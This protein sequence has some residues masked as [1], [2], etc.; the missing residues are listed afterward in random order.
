MDKTNDNQGNP[1]HHNYLIFQT[2]EKQVSS[3]KRI[4][5][6]I[7]SKEYIASMEADLIS[8]MR[9]NLKGEDVS[10]NIVDFNELC[11][12]IISLACKKKSSFGDV[13]FIST[14]PLIAY[15]TGGTCLEIN[16]LI[17]FNGEIIGIGTRPGF[18]DLEQQISKVQKKSVV[19]LEDGSWTG[20]TMQFV[21]NGL[22]EQNI[23]VRA[24]ILGVLSSKAKYVLGEKEDIEIFP[25]IP[26]ASKYIEWMP[27][28]DFIPFFPNAGRVIGN[29][30][31]K[32]C[33]P[34]YLYNSFSLCKPYVYPY[35]DP[36]TWASLS[37]EK[38]ELA[39]S[40]SVQFS[41]EC[42]CIAWRFF[43][44]MDKLNGRILKIE[45]LLN[46]YPAVSL[47]ITSTA[48]QIFHKWHVPCRNEI[49]LDTAKDTL[50]KDIE[51]L[52]FLGYEDVKP[53]YNASNQSLVFNSSL[54]GNS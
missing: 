20:Q 30:I 33:F 15:E 37:G 4:G 47:P 28:H 35:G 51:S 38:T 23:K 13:E 34:I 22:E 16:R 24:I 6:V 45:D 36:E 39:N 54:K 42:L 41:K 7:P 8:L 32:K 53:H 43:D 17:N 2:L 5:L 46:C 48:G 26:N 19:I 9:E 52:S 27:T 21:I 12:E 25:I 29:F 11:D 49:F 31:G 18:P 1:P 40:K 10:L 14:S 3:F 50:A 44:K